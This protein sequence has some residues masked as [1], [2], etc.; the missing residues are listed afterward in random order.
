MGNTSS[1]PQQATAKL[2]GGYRAIS[3]L[4]LGMVW[5]AYRWRSIS[6][7]DLRLYLALHEV[8]E[9]RHAANVGKNGR[10]KGGRVPVTGAVLAELQALVHCSRLDQVRASLRRL[11]TAGLLAPDQQYLDLTGNL[12]QVPT[13]RRAAVAEM[14]RR[15]G[16][17]RRVPVPRRALR[18]MAGMKSAA[19]IATLLAATVRCVYLH[20][21]GCSAEGSCSVRFIAEAFG[22]HPRTVK[23]ARRHLQATGWLIP[24]DADRWHVQRHGARL[25]FNLSTAP[26]ST[27]SAPRR[28]A[29]RTETPPRRHNRKLRSESQN[30]KPSVVP[31]AVSKKSPG[32]RPTGLR[33][34]QVAELQDADKLATRWAAAVRM[35]L[36]QESEADRLRFYGAAVH[37]LRVAS[38][39]PC[40]LFATVVRRK[41]WGYLSQAD[42]DQARAL[43]R[44]ADRRNGP[45]AAAADRGRMRGLVAGVAARFAWPS[46][47]Q[48]ITRRS[49]SP[50]LSNRWAGTS[51]RSP[52]TVTATST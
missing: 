40:G 29:I 23:A 16:R 13:G 18:A 36:V 14:N 19:V 52:P 49:M 38:R 17:R 10:N 31:K 39:N 48:M 41:L 6:L 22:V 5:S 25:R 47:Q 42:E 28:P 4:Q 26:A 45:E 34:L 15:L 2:P 7:L 12:D 35:G 9:R 46:N 43:L 33:R 51:A 37:A 11:R 8:A 20:Q 21:R 44:S 1:R 32:T 24:L 3:T 50:T 27:D 30:Q